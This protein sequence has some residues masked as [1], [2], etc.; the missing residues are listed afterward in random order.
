MLV[1]IDESGDSGWKIEQGSTKY[2]VVALVVF[3]DLDEAL[4]CDQRISLLRRELG[5]KSDYEF[6]YS[7]NSDRA[8][9]EFLK[10]ISPY[11]FFYYGIVINK[12]PK[13]LYG[14]G[15]KYKSPFYKY[16]CG[17]V[18]ENAKDK[19]ANAVVIIDESGS[20]DF[21]GELKKYLQKKVNGEGEN[22]IKK[23]K[24][25]R[26][27]SN[28]LIQLAD[29]VA[30]VIHGSVRDKSKAKKLR[31]IIAHREIDVQIWPK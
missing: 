7:A 23:V 11:S 13:K 22:K 24:Q 20:K 25:Q 2:F 17:L 18:F 16:A 31:T 6:H 8:K 28:N 4:A 3:E 29:Y 10:A 30:G 15:F 9:E 1:L 5:L 27:D 26:S 14:P 21:K 12:D 19:L